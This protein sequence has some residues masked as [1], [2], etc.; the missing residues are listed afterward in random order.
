VEAIMKIK[1][2]TLSQSGTAAVEFALILPLLLIIVFGIIEFSIVFY[3]K[4]MITNASREGARYGITFI[5]EGPDNGTHP[6]EDK[7]IA[8]VNNYVDNGTRLI[9]FSSLPATI[10][11]AVDGENGEPG[12]DLTVTVTYPYDFLILP[13]FADRVANLTLSAETVMRLE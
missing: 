5:Y 12:D 13:R 8:K 1:S 9:S 11:T 7:I 6:T 10:T 4:A 2:E 3:N